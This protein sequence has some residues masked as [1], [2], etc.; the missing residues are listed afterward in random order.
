MNNYHIEA[1]N[2]DNWRPGMKHRQGFLVR[3]KPHKKFGWLCCG[4]FATLEEAKHFAS[5]QLTQDG[6]LK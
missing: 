6:D 3:Y 5:H 2:A 4:T 1:I